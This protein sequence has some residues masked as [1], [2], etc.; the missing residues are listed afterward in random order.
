MES[1]AASVRSKEDEGG[2]EYRDKVA[3]FGIARG[4]S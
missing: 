4:L 3:G 1:G 2:L